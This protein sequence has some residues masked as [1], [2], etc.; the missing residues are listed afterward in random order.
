MYTFFSNFPS[1][2]YNDS[3]AVNI[4]A[5]VKFND[6]VKRIAAVYYPYT[7]LDG[8]RPDMIAS[9]YYGDSRYSWLIY[10]ANDIVDPYYEW[11]LTGTEFN[12]YIVKKYGS[13]SNCKRS[14]LYWRVNWNNDE[15]TLDVSGYN[16]LPSN[17]K[18]YFRPVVG[19]SGNIV[20]YVRSELDYT[21]ETNK[22][23]S[24][25]VA[26]AT[27]FSVG[28]Y[29]T[30]T[31]SGS[32]SGSGFIKEIS[33]NNIVAQNI[34]GT[35]SATSGSLSNLI[36]DTVSSSISSVT[37]ISDGIPSDELVYW[38]YVNAYDY[39]NEVNE[40]KRYI[41]MLDRSYLSQV[42]KEIGELL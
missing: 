39:E 12:E 7:I 11:P 13:V 30:Q 14:I 9:N 34:L 23:I 19:Y 35:F 1:I 15:T 4:I 33:D 17:R 6:V 32:L 31:T 28:N 16:A 36:S 29:I 18:K 2:T 20:N 24:I 10:L 38:T 42:E 26:D 27:G 22:T 25:A 37:S 3:L 40:S 41:R 5:K 8:E 21:V